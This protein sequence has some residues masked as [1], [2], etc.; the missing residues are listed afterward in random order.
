MSSKLNIF[1]MLMFGHEVAVADVRQQWSEGSEPL[2]DVLA[3]GKDRRIRK[4][5]P[6]QISRA[7]AEAAEVDAGIGVGNDALPFNVIGPGNRPGGILNAA[8]A[9]ADRRTAAELMDGRDLP[10]THDL[11]RYAAHVQ[12]FVGTDGQL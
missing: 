9:D 11:A 7:A 6:V 2:N 12:Q 1:W 8:R 5:I 3:A 4:G 10:A